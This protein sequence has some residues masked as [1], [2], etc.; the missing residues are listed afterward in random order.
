MGWVASSAASAHEVLYPN[1]SIGVRA[2]SRGNQ[3]GVALVLQGLN[4]LFPERG[5]MLWCHVRLTW[6][7]RLIE[8]HHAS[9]V[10]F[11]DKLREFGDLVVTPQHGHVPE[12]DTRIDVGA[13]G[14]DISDVLGQERIDTRRTIG[15]A[16]TD[17]AT[18][19]GPGV[20]GVR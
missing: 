3:H 12:I 9:G 8:S 10:A 19:S 16:K 2:R 5:A 13:P 17:F 11:L 4:V 6:L 1:Q 7:V 15:P 20:T 14:V 18:T